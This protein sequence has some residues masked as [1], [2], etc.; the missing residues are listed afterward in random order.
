MPLDNNISGKETEPHRTTAGIP[1]CMVVKPISGANTSWEITIIET[2]H[3]DTPN[4]KVSG[5]KV[6]SGGLLQFSA[7]I[8]TPAPF[9]K[10]RVTTPEGSASTVE[11][12]FWDN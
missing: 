7:G 6:S 8:T 1:T 11:I 10:A 3:G 9:I 5:I 4:E 2:G 12:E